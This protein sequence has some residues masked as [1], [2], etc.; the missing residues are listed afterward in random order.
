MATQAQLDQQQAYEAQRNAD[1]V[2]NGCNQ[3]AAAT[4]TS[5]KSQLD[6]NE[7]QP[8]NHHSDHPSPP[9]VHVQNNNNYIGGDE[10]HPPETMN[11]KALVVVNRV[12]DKLTGRDF[13]PNVTFDVP[14]Q[15]DLLVKQATSNEN[16]SQ[17][18]I[19]WCAFW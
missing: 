8:T 5:G 17:C 15:I 18:Y 16:L 11:S 13:D 9:S 12:R 6:G 1:A 7:H 3:S 4:H 2:A 19:G 10:Q 14:N